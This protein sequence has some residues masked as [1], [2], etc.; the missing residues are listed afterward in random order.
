[1]A[2]PI[3]LATLQTGDRTAP[4]IPPAP[5]AV[6]PVGIDRDSGPAEPSSRFAGGVLLSSGEIAKPPFVT[7]G[8]GSSV[9]GLAVTRSITNVSVTPAV[10]AGFTLPPG[11]FRHSATNALLTVEAKLSDGRPLPSWLSFDV[12]TGRFTGRPPAGAD[13]ILSIRI[14]VRD[15]QG[16]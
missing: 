2:A 14:M 11:L 5:P 7:L 8:G 3:I 4:G 6:Y 10:D 9:S 16:A 13:G 15:D 12:S 1:P